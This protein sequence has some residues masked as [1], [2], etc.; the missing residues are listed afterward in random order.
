[1]NVKKLFFKSEEQKNTFYSVVTGIIA[2]TVNGLFGGGGGMIVVPMLM[3]FLK[4]EAKTAHATAILII[5]PL[6]VVSAIFYALFGSVD[7]SVAFPTTIGVIVGGAAGAFLLSKLSSEYIVII[8]AAVMFA[9]G[10]K[11]L[12]F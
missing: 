9:A 6:S 4:K 11:M 2:G 1:M 12:F 10:C 3:I 5:L 8:F 7:V